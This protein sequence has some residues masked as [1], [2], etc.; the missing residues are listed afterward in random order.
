MNQVQARIIQSYSPKAARSKKWVEREMKTR[1]E[2]NLLIR[3]LYPRWSNN[4]RRGRCDKKRSR[5]RSGLCRY[6]PIPWPKLVIDALMYSR[7]MQLSQSMV[8]SITLSCPCLNLGLPL[9]LPAP[10]QQMRLFRRKL[11]IQVIYVCLRF[12]FHFILLLFYLGILFLISA[13][14]MSYVDWCVDIPG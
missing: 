9:P 13:D 3:S 4:T 2:R 10:V 14:F 7:I 12:N 6:H 5:M 11:L 8:R 1:H